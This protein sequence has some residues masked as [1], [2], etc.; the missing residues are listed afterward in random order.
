MDRNTHESGGNGYILKITGF[1]DAAT[2]RAC[3][4]QMRL[5]LHWLLLEYNLAA[6]PIPALRDV[7]YADDPAETAHRWKQS[8]GHD[9]GDRID[10]VVDGN[11]PS[12]YRTDENIRAITIGTATATVS[13]KG[14]DVAGKLLESIERFPATTPADLSAAEPDSRLETALDLYRA[15]VA[16][17]SVRARFLT[18]MM[19]ME[20]LC[21]PESRPPDVQRLLQDFRACAEEMKDAEGADAETRAVLGA[22]QQE[23]HFRS[24]DSIRNQVRRLIRT[25]LAGDDDVE[26]RRE[27]L[28]DLYGIRSQLTHGD[29]LGQNE[30]GEAFPRLRDIARRI[31]RAR[32]EAALGSGT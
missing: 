22:L 18:V 24:R 15:H 30:L 7:R 6:K 3:D 2:A 10:G 16:E 20:A 12:V 13:R 5:A 26:Q 31:L 21:E 23:L 11:C 14:E 25:S 8:M 29:A 17:Q 4:G 9:F 19:A 27:E 32:P 1:P 28:D